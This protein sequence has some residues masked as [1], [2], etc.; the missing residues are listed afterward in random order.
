MCIYFFMYVM[1]TQSQSVFTGCYS[2]EAGLEET[3]TLHNSTST[4]VILTPSGE[5]ADGGTTGQKI[6]NEH[7]Y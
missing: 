2:Y 1:M 3:F 5:E 4:T 6:N 7:R